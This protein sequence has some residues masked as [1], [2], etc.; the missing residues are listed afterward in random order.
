MLAHYEA[1]P[2]DPGIAEALDD[3]VARRTLELAGSNLYE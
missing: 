2:L 1:P 3:Y